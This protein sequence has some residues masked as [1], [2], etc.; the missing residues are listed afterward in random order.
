MHGC[1]LAA[2]NYSDMLIEDTN[3]SSQR[4]HVHTTNKNQ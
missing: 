3:W 4:F 1:V 2:K